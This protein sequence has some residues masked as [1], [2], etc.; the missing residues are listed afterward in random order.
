[1][2]TAELSRL[3]ALEREH[4]IT[5][6]AA[7]QPITPARAA[8]AI[9]R[10]LDPDTDLAPRQY[11]HPEWHTAAACTDLPDTLFFGSENEWPTIRPIELARVRAVCH[12][13][14]VRWACLTWA[15]TKGEEYGVWA[16]TTG[17]DRARLQKRIAAGASVAELVQQAQGIEQFRLKT[18]ARPATQPE[19]PARPAARAPRVT[20]QWRV[21]AA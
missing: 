3:T 6:R 5:L 14:P 20:R 8:A 1:M 13:C 15:L 19:R 18:G 7:H 2:I 16:G 11:P 10:V 21:K 12:S 4:R 9:G 17:R